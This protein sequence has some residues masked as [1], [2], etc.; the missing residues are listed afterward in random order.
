MDSA[1]YKVQQSRID[2]IL[3]RLHELDPGIPSVEEAAIRADL[4]TLSAEHLSLVENSTGKNRTI[5]SWSALL[6]RL[7]ALKEGDD[8]QRLG[9]HDHRRVWLA[10]QRLL[11]T[12]G[13][14]ARLRETLA[15]LFSWQGLVLFG[16]FLLAAVSINLAWRPQAKI[17]TKPVQYSTFL[18]EVE[19]KN[20]KVVNFEEQSRKIYF[21][22]RDEDEAF[23]AQREAGQEKKDIIDKGFLK[24]SVERTVASPPRPARYLTRRVEGDMKLIEKL[25]ASGAAFRSVPPSSLDG[26]RTALFTMVAIYV[27]LIPLFIFARRQLMGR[28]TKKRA[29]AHDS[30][31]TFR[32]VAGVDQAKQELMEVVQFMKNKG[33]YRKL[34]A[35]LPK[36][37]LLVGP[38]GTGKTLLARAMAGE[39]GVPFLSVSASEFVEM[40]VG[41]GAARV[42]ELFAEARAAAAESAGRR[43]A[44]PGA[45]REAGTCVVF[46]DELDAVGGKRGLSSNEER[47]Q[48]LNQLLTEMDGFDAEEGV[49]VLAATNRAE[50]LDAGL[51]R[52]GRFD[53][54]VFVGAPD[55]EGRQAILA[56]H[57]RT[58]P[59]V[60]DKGAIQRAVAR[61][62]PGFVG[63]DLANVVNEATLLAI[64]DG[65]EVVQLDDF[66][67]AVDR[68][69]FGIGRRKGP[70]QNLQ[71]G[72]GRW[73]RKLGGELSEGTELAG[74][75]GDGGPIVP[76]A[77]TMN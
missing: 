62:T 2:T 23:R 76:K 61:V 72:F 36:G 58:T 68:S 42:R 20:V 21:A 5:S 63:A 15:R 53:R 69:R 34:G 30:A 49:L 10:E 64:R 46:I 9:R 12:L 37:V 74:G 55:A 71:Q 60:G 16:A 67:E 4:N 51:L 11:K 6:K 25:Q 24:I 17:V 8:A 52:P 27:P 14:A 39:A 66:L 48:T 19:K 41:R 70:I 43:G 47:D 22:L 44:R 1:D 73:L 35:K 18:Q 13:W 38:P 3:A 45:P 26:M 29:R 75:G 77:V 57:M 54:K 40:F 50:V 31:V 33:K 59:V 28:A 56:V 7:I 32:D 65:R